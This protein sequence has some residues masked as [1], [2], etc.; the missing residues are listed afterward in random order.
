MLLAD[1]GQRFLG[2]ILTPGG[3]Q[4]TGVFGGVG[5]A[6]HH[7]LVAVAVALIPIK[8]QQRIDAIWSV[9]EIIQRFEQWGDADVVVDAGA[10][11]SNGV[12]GS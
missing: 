1:L 5:V 10:D 6:D 4:R 8:L 7:L 11:I 2:S 12:T 9:V 3:S